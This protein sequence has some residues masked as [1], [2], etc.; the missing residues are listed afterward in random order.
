MTLLSCA[1]VRKR[2]VRPTAAAWQL[3]AYP[4]AS[5]ESWLLVRLNERI[6]QADVLLNLEGMLVGMLPRLIRLASNHS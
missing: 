1:I 4:A 2:N 3:M 5:A 6:P